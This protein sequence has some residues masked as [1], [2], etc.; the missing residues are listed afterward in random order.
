[1][2]ENIGLYRGKRIDNGGWRFGSLLKVEVKGVSVWLIYGSEFEI[3]SGEVYTKAY[4]HVDPETVGEYTGLTDKNG[5]MIF[6]GDILRY[7]YGGV[8]SVEYGRFNCTCCNGV[9]GWGVTRGGDIRDCEN[10]EIIGNIH[11][12]PE[13][14]K[15]E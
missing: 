13:L 2:R 11:D 10:H 9:Y 7:E 4:G 12:N 6:E 15:G 1:M 8:C 5:K 14:V 3:I